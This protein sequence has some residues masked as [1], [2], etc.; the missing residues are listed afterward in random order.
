VSARIPATPW[1][2]T[3]A[4]EPRRPSAAARRDAVVRG[5]AVAGAN[6]VA[7]AAATVLLGAAVLLSLD[8]VT[9]AVVLALVLLLCPLAGLTWHGFRTRTWPAWLAAP[10]GAV[11]TVLYGRDSGAVLADLGLLTVTEGSV[12]LALVIL[13]RVLAVA[14]PSIVLFATVDPTAL[15]D[16]LAQVLHLPA[17]FVLGALAGVRLTGLMLD[18]WRSLEL[19]RR[20]RGVADRGRL[21]RLASQAFALLVLAVR[22]GAKLATA[23]EARGFG[24]DAPRTWARPSRLG[25]IDAALVAVAALIGASAVAVSVATGSWRFLLA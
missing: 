19:A 5:G 1:T 14:I 9:P 15:A 16:G 21:R 23:M 4:P 2:T 11:T 3:G 8:P 17:R 20:A 12:S 10:L 7:K 13:L 25:R 18:D 22:R 24:A 6:P